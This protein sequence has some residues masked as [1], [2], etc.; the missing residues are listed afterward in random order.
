MTCW[1]G[2]LS[3]RTKVKDV[4]NTKY[5]LLVRELVFVLKELMFYF[6]RQSQPLL[7]CL[8][9]LIIPAPHR[10]SALQLHG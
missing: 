4:L 8:S 9:E 7:S 2:K 3:H 5:G 1:L 10:L 6:Y